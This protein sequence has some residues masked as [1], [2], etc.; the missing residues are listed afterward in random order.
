MSGLSHP[1]S[2]D[3][4]TQTSLIFHP[5]EM[6]FGIGSADGMIRVMGCNLT[7][8]N[9]P[10]MQNSTENANDS[11]NSYMSSIYSDSP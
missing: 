8:Q 9:A 5:N 10:S 2:R 1:P 3:S 7:D 4:Y 11:R 6:L